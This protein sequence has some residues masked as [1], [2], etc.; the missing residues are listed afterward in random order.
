MGSP[1]WGGHLCYYRILLLCQSQA[2]SFFLQPRHEASWCG[3]SVPR[4]GIEPRPQRWRCWVL[5][6]RPPGNIQCSSL[7][8]SS[9][10]LLSP[11]PSL[12]LLSM[13]NPEKIKAIRRKISHLFTAVSSKLS[14]SMFTYPAFSPPIINIFS[15][16]LLKRG[17]YLCFWSHT[18]LLHHQNIS[19]S[20]VI[21]INIQM[22]YN[23]F[24]LK[25]L[26]M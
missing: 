1:V 21:P 26:E 8:T 24:Y 16:I 20:W 25:I 11:P 2:S 17:L 15:L 9:N 22:C 18:L 13:Y 10:L 6:T 12:S 5:T 14:T 4:P 3:I 19:P 7:T 23:I